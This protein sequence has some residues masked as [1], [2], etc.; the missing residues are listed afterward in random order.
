LQLIEDADVISGWNSTGFDIPYIVNRITQVNG[1]GKDYTRSLCLWNELPKK[2]NYIQYKAEKIT[3]E[4]VGRVHLDYLDLYRKHTY[5]ERLS[6]RLDYISEVE[7]GE[8]KIAYDGTLDSL[9]NNDFKKFIEYNRQDVMLLEKI[10][11]KLKFIS[12]SNQLAHTNT[13]LL[14]TTMGS[15]ALIEQ[16]IINEAHRLEKV[17]PNRKVD[18]YD[19]SH[20]DEDD[21][22][23]ED[24]EEVS[25]AGAYVADPKTGLH[26]YVG[27][28]DINSLYPSAIRALN[29]GPETLVGQVRQTKT[30]ALI[31]ERLKAMKKKSMALAW[32]GIF[33]TLEYNDIMEK[34]EEPLIL[35]LESGESLEISAAELYGYIFE[36]G[37]PFCISANGTLFRTDKESIIAGLLARW[38]SERQSMQKKAKDY[39]KLAEGL[40][41]EDLDLLN[42]LK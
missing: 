26:D 19:D 42:A 25:A 16:A 6:Y 40:V 15:V 2:K 1:L 31:Q 20:S 5:S 28:V 24:D 41:I 17:V 29:M 27:G 4:L 8:K 33:A 14:K 3:Y 10:D 18:A 23:D 30:L 36:D 12:L 34:T 37:N 13:V 32:S 9:Y 39:K 11:K 38:Y 7:V 21:D 35:D 22:D